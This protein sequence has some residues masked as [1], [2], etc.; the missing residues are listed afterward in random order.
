MADLSYGDE[1]PNT[2]N[3]VIEIQKGSVNKYELDKST[4]KIFLD[5]VNGTA[6]LG[7]PADYGYVPD[8]LCEDGDP[9]DAL[10]IIDESVPPGIVV[11][12]RPIGVLNMVDDGEGDEKLVC[13][14]ND[15]VTK[16][17]IESVED[18]GDNFKPMVEH[19]YSQYKAW[20]KNW[21]GTPVSFNGWGSAEEAKKIIRQSIELAQKKQG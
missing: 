15:D 8:T 3:V 18:L 20:K 6:S 4:G 14:A 12:A 10:L 7:Y 1:A 11:P 2:V 9:L 16:S 19:F 5:R 17:H 13:V 21:Q